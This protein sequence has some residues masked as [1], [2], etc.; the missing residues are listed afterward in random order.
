MVG[1]FTE[2]KITVI[3]CLLAVCLDR[4]IECDPIT[5]C[6][7]QDGYLPPNCCTCDYN[8]NNPQGMIYYRDGDR[9]LRKLLRATFLLSCDSIPC[10]S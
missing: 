4:A 1:Y 2:V 6:T 5:G 3:P 8:G 10:S 9:C 7:C